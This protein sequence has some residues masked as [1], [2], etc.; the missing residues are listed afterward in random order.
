MR[1][2][3]LSLI[4][5]LVVT[6]ASVGCA[7]DPNKNASDAHDAELKAQREQNQTAAGNAGDR[8]EDA[9]EQRRENV[10]NTAASSGGGSATKERVGAEAKL[11]EA[12]EVYRSKATERLAKLDAKTAELKTLIDRAGSKATTKS[13]DSL[14]TVDTQ[15][16]AVTRDI[17]QLRSVPD[18][19][20]AAARTNVE[21]QLDTLDGLVKKTAKDVEEFKR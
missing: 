19:N 12:R 5:C 17:D 6:L 11:N 21:T 14:R 13:R 16:A 20:L 3:R 2:A 10:E 4:T 18:D 7:S 8:R 1:I 15:R 9:A